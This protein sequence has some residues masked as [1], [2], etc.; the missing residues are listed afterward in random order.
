MAGLDNNISN[1]IGKKLPQWVLNQLET[2]ANQNS[3]D[4]RDNDN[5]LYLANKTAWVRLV[6]SINISQSDQNYFKSILEVSN[7]TNAESLAKEFILFGGTSKYLNKDSYKQRSGLGKDGAY[8]ILGTKEIQEF[9]YRPMPGITSVNIDTQGRLG[10]VRSATINFKCWDKSQLDIIDTLY[11][12]LGFTMFLEWG[13]TFYYPSGTNKIKS[14][15]EY[16]IDP[17]QKN[18]TKEEISFQIAKSSR[19]SEGNYDAMLGMVTNFNFSYNQEGGY[20]CTLKIIALGALG[21]SIKINN[22]GVLPNLL[23]EEILLYNDTLN[24]ITQDLAAKA[25]AA[26][27]VANIPKLPPKIDAINA[28][29]FFNKYITYYPERA[30]KYSGGQVS[31]N[32]L[33]NESPKTIDAVFDTQAYGPVY[34]IRK[35]KG[36]IPLS[37]SYRS[38]V[39]VSLDSSRIISK[40]DSIKSST[41]A[42]GAQDA[43]NWEFPANYLENAKDI[44]AKPITTTVNLLGTLIDVFTVSKLGFQSTELNKANDIGEL[45]IPY[46]STNGRSYNLKISRKL[47]AT[48]EREDIVDSY[49]S[50]SN[51]LS[52]TN[53]AY[54]YIDTETFVKQLKNVLQTEKNT[55]IIKN[56]DAIPNKTTTTFSF[57]IPFTRKT[58][59]STKGKI[60]VDVINPDG[61][62]TKGVK[63]PDTISEADV[64]YQLSVELSTDDS[65]FIKNFTVPENV[66]E[67]LDFAAQKKLVAQDVKEVD[68]KEEQ[69][70]A[71][72]AIT[73]QIKQAISLQ[74]SL[75]ITLRAI[76][77]H[78]LNQAINKSGND[79]EIGRKVYKLDMLDSNQRKFTDQIFT[80]GI[81]TSF[82]NELLSGSIDT[83][84][85]KDENKT[86]TPADRLK[87][88]SKYGFATSLL[89]NKANIDTIEPTNFSQILNAYVVPYQIN[90]EIIK[91]VSTNHPVYIPL[92]LLLM[93][94]NHTCTIYDTK[95]NDFQTPLVYLDFNTEINF[96]LSN[97]KQL[98][99]NPWVTL[100]P[101]EG[102]NS[103]FAQL[104]DSKVLEKNNTQISAV[105]GSTEVVK[106]YKPETEDLLSG[107][108][109]PIK[110]DTIE[111]SNPYRGK[112]MNILLN[113]DYLVKLVEEYS[114]K[115]GTN[116]VY[117]K[118]FLEQILS[119]L[120]KYL[121][122]FNAFRLAYNDGAN[123][124]QIVDDQFLP[125]LSGE[126]QVTPDNRKDT[127][128]TDNRTGL[129]LYGKTSIA[130]SL[131]IKTEISNKLGN[132]IAISANSTVSN[133]A[134]LSTNGDA[135]G[136]IN[137][138]YVD[139][140]I[141]DAL[142]PTGSGGAKINLDTIK[143]SA[144]QFNQT[145]TD[146]YS[147]I[148]P[149]ENSI[150]HATNYY[151]DKMSKIKNEDFA[152]RAAP[153][154]PVSV[155]FTTDGI[156]GMG[157][158]H[159]FTIPDQLLPYTYS[160]RNSLQNLDP[161]Q[162]DH[163]NKV[164][165]VMIGLTHTIESNQWNTAVRANMIFL[166][167]KTDFKGEVK[168]LPPKDEVFGV[169]PNKGS[170][171]HGDI[172]NFVSTG[173]VGSRVPRNT[174]Q[175]ISYKV[176]Q[177]SQYIFD[178]NKSL[179]TSVS[180]NAHGARD[181]SQVGQWQSTNAWDL[182]VPAFTPVYAIYD[183]SV[184]NINYYEEGIFI[185]G[186]RFTL[187]GSNS[188]FYTHLDRVVP[189]EGASV[190]KGD[191]LG[192]VG[193]PP[194]EFR[195]SPHL[196]IALQ[197]GKLSTY[198]SNDGKII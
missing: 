162:K 184:T 84:I 70:K 77:I 165:F 41:G 114:Q 136:Y 170:L 19:K 62:I 79:L 137:T 126:D 178:S 81:F 75:E 128:D 198:I 174:D 104:F 121:G 35:Q 51:G 43:R 157:M 187:I 160:T 172:N 195:W 147:K 12:K 108:L 50:I 89:G 111:I 102:S 2:R 180:S 154:I 96:C 120:N 164:G 40:I 38:L 31:L 47:W 52:Y 117:L 97:P 105:S 28:E 54:Y 7:I 179:G 72:D 65:S 113:I 87:I 193:K 182:M 45:D 112:V 173:G 37:D 115:N 129:P 143:N 132:M 18:L 11:F 118:T 100:I 39:N 94:L 71:Q 163:I 64:T 76:Q 21:D 59:I 25:A 57:T 138:S 168:K 125:A 196:H 22:A 171:L 10:S 149:S 197:S 16:A 90:Q 74:S 119:D 177:N 92:S 106:L 183:G 17:F 176:S 93:I 142:E 80:N 69:K 103:D 144:A 185:W 145:I 116:S 152:T 26:A 86:V 23:E 159:A 4:S 148:N 68:T 167:D 194:P 58:K 140:Y 78:A 192:F 82:L 34:F 33:D 5:I 29:D 175:T 6:S 98:T 127:P 153:M 188:A 61:T 161:K 32:A 101:F 55:F 30:N 27:N 83:S 9:G 151:I 15:E 134:A 73:A 60:G 155:N 3:K 20:D 8:G 186:W 66:I 123:T 49:G 124:F 190:K 56:V 44:I 88:Y 67:P 107:N 181:Q 24:R 14:T 48:S 109:P 130:K 36:F 110:F 189:K 169:N 46:K 158:G 131:E 85:Y 150:G 1:I 95:N 135:V 122:K 146:F 191:L 156:S 133:K 141:P 166:K 13:H 91:G 53:S 63:T 42:I 99:T 139:R